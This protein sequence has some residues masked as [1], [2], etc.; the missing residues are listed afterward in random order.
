MLEISKKRKTDNGDP[1]ISILFRTLPLDIVAIIFQ[2]VPNFSSKF[3]SVATLCSLPILMDHI[4]RRNEQGNLVSALVWHKRILFPQQ[5]TTTT[6]Q[7]QYILVE[8]PFDETMWLFSSSFGWSSKGNLSFSLE[9]DQLPSDYEWSSY[10]WYLLLRSSL[11][12]FVVDTTLETVMQSSVM[13]LNQFVTMLERRD[14]TL[15]TEFCLLYKESHVLEVVKRM[16]QQQWSP[17]F[18]FI[19]TYVKSEEGSLVEPLRQLDECKRALGDSV[20]YT[21]L[22][23]E[24][25]M[26]QIIAPEKQPLHPVDFVKLYDQNEA[27]IE[28]GAIN[29]PKCSILS[30]PD[31]DYLLICKFEQF[32][33]AIV[34]ESVGR[35]YLLNDAILFCLRHCIPHLFVASSVLGGSMDEEEWSTIDKCNHE[36]EH[37]HKKLTVHFLKKNAATTRAMRYL[38]PKL[39]IEYSRNFECFIPREIDPFFGETYVE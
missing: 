4:F 29:L 13:I 20:V 10:H 28:Y 26:V 12:R 21:R 36:M 9:R 8:Y 22:D 18:I 15:R 3:Y 14:R 31:A 2:Y 27:E 23:V 25:N 16:L 39:H 7:S 11:K 17:Q 38:F 34:L 37:N 1:N 33:E 6:A 35:M 24:L 5:I 32:P 30:I 19:L